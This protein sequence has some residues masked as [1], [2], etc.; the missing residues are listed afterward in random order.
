MRT[1]LLHLAETKVAILAQQQQQQHEIPLLPAEN[2]GLRGNGQVQQQQQQQQAFR[3]EKKLIAAQL[4]QPMVDNSPVL[5]N[6]PPPPLADE[7]GNAVNQLQQQQ[8]QPE[9][10]KKPLLGAVP[11]QNSQIPERFADLPPV[12]PPI[13]TDQAESLRL[14]QGGM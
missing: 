5:L 2:V 6:Q 4:P 1:A 14:E 9:E 11:Q 13:P 10:D 12:L 3:E 8:Q 7:Q